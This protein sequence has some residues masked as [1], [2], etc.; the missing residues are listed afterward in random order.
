M[1]TSLITTLLIVVS[2]YFIKKASKKKS[3]V[4]ENGN[5][6]HKLPLLYGIGGVV[7]LIIST[8]IIVATIFDSN[9]T[10]LFNSTV[11]VCL[12]S[13][14]GLIMCLKVWMNRISMNSEEIVQRNMWGKIKTIKMNEIRS[15]KFNRFSL[16][17][18]ISDGKKTI[19]C[20][21]HLVGIEEILNMLT[22]KTNITRK[23][24]GYIE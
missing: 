14:L 16:Y 15:I 23:Q 13:S 1:T 22:E 19:K 7:P 6:I 9:N 12:F 10:N 20:H 24:M 4:D 8:I 5:S 21:D 17:L 3:K 2:L 11:L 18:K